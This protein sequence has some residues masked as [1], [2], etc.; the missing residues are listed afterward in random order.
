MPSPRLLSRQLLLPPQHALFAA[1]HASTLAAVPGGRLLGA[2]FAGTREGAGDTA[3]WLAAREH[4]LWQPP[5][6]LFAEPGLGHWNPVLHAEGERVWLFYKVGPDVQCWTTRVATSDDGGRSWSAPAPLVAGETAPRGPVKNKLVRL[7]DGTW[8][9]GSSVESDRAWDA[10]ADLSPDRGRSWQRAEVPFDHRPSAEG[11]AE[12]G[13]KWAGL[14]A[15]ALW[16]NDPGRAFAWDGVIQPTVWESAPGRAHMLLRS[17][18]GH[19]YRSDS[20]DGGRHWCPAYPTALPNNNSGIDLARLDDG[21][22]AL[23]CNPVAGNW[24]RR[25]PLSLLLSADNGASWSH[26]LDLETREGEFS[27]PAVLA[28]ERCLHVSYTADR[29][30]IVHV[31]LEIPPL[32]KA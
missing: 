25:T 26:T 2:F 31:T 4:G 1:C 10:F 12:G 29:R 8:L 11:T 7:S 20:A 32:G 18:R 23:A 15:E 19:I 9:A 16:E 13:E 14:A 30:T 27:Y 5:R 28:A 24:G 6:R 22:L 17:T 3:I 21:R